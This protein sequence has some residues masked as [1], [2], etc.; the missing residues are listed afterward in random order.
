[1]SY[2]ILCDRCS[3]TGGSGKT[4]H[5][6]QEWER[7]GMDI[8]VTGATYKKWHEYCPVCAEYLRLASDPTEE[9]FA[10]RLVAILESMVEEF[11]DEMN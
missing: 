2:I 3:N 6:P 4:G 11:V 1:M 5:L 9:T 8:H 10:E 7:V